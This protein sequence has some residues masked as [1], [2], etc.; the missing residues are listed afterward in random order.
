MFSR[1][2]IANRGEIAVRTIRDK[3]AARDLADSLGV[4]TIPGYHGE[5]QDIAL[6]QAEAETIGYPLM[7]K[8]A[9]GGGGRGMR[10]VES[11]DDLENAVESGHRE[12][13]R[14]FGDGR[15]L[16]ERAVQNARHI[17]VQVL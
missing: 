11:P 1:V 3:S 17:E 6:L 2:L 10:L 8:A 7:V 14:A 9:M 5:G 16:L 15:L 4:P 12:A 13:E